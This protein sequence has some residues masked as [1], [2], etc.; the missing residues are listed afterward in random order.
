[1]T[2]MNNNFV[3]LQVRLGLSGQI[4]LKHPQTIGVRELQRI[5][6]DQGIIA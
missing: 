5:L 3:D 2:A 6:P 4:E 1:M